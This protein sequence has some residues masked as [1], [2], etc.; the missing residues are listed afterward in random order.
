MPLSS[1]RLECGSRGACAARWRVQR[2]GK[3]APASTHPCLSRLQRRLRA[4]C[5][6]RWRRPRCQPRLQVRVRVCVL[7]VSRQPLQAGAAGAPTRCAEPR[8]RGCH[9]RGGAS[10]AV[11]QHPC[12]ICRA[13]V[14]ARHRRRRRRRHG[15]G[16]ALCRCNEP[17]IA[18]GHH[19]LSQQLWRRAAGKERQPLR[20]CRIHL[21]RPLKV[22]PRFVHTPEA[23]KPTKV[24]N[25]RREL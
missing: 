13:A 6:A 23:V 20:G 7:D 4:R 5:R 16:R 2:S 14:C 3:P 1:R 22:P 11:D 21:E 9:R 18:Q 8:G 25:A 19:R 17:R 24:R 10:T 15:G 12:T